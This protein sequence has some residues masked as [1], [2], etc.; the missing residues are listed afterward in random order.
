MDHQPTVEFVFVD[1]PDAQASPPDGSA[2]KSELSRAL[3][4]AFGRFKQEMG[5]R[6]AELGLSPVQARS[7]RHL[8][9]PMT[10]RELAD[11]TATEPSNLTPVVDRLESAG[12]VQRRP[13]PGDRRIRELCL[14]AEGN[15]TRERLDNEVLATMP[16]FDRLS[17]PQQTQLLRLLEK[18]A[19]GATP[20]PR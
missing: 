3:M 16:I 19:A 15:R 1:G 7:L 14:T 4:A 8:E 5:P 9:N 11:A 17:R 6:L 13:K 18:L 10:M 12:L 20:S 2:T